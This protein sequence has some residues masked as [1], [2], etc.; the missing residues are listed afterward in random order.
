MQD[1]ERKKTMTAKIQPN[2]TYSATYTCRVN[3]KPYEALAGQGYDF[4]TAEQAQ[5]AIDQANREQDA[6]I[7]AV[8]AL[9]YEHAITEPVGSTWY[10]PVFWGD[11][12]IAT[13]VY[14]N[15]RYLL[16]QIDEQV[17]L[18]MGSADFEFAFS[19]HQNAVAEAASWAK[20]F[21][22]PAAELNACHYCGCKATKLG[23]FGEPVCSQCG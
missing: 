23:F 22:T 16:S 3:G 18:S 2:G 15:G 19:V 20:N 5:Q 21:E 1:K 12:E 14:N 11:P 8:D 6:F 10:R 9:D 4:D 13:I 17:Y 7:S